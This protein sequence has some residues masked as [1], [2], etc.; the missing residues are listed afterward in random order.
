MN[1]LMDD[2]SNSLKQFVKD[3][4]DPDFYDTII[5]SVLHAFSNKDTIVRYYQCAYGIIYSSSTYAE[6]QFLRGLVIITT[7]VTIRI[8]QQERSFS[9]VS[10]SGSYHLE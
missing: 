4:S 2:V 10:Y 1:N 9:K 5:T 7:T 3:N 6:Y 8:S